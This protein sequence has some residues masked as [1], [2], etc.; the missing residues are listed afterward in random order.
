MRMAG[1]FTTQIPLLVGI[2]VLI[3]VSFVLS[4][5]ALSAGNSTNYHGQ[6]AILTFNTTSLRGNSPTAPAIADWYE[7]NYLSVCSGMWKADTASG[8]KNQNTITCAHQQAGYTFSLAQTLGSNVGQ[9]LPAGSTYGIIDTKGPLVLLIIGI[10][11][12]GTSFTSLL[13]GVVV[14]LLTGT[15]PLFA[16]RIGYLA[17]IPTAIILTISSAKITALADKMKGATEISPGVVVH[18]WMGWSFYL[19]TWLAAGFMWAAVCFS[20]A[21]AFKIARSIELQNSRGRKPL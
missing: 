20:I 11:L 3:I 16:L 8:N 15:P 4:I 18:A 19:S 6:S 14:L 1:P 17:S 12:A 7:M 9:L 5:L 13:Y 21:G 10:A 2:E